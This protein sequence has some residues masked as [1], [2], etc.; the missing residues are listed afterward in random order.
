MVEGLRAGGLP[1]SWMLYDEKPE[2]HRR[3]SDVFIDSQG[4]LLSGPIPR[5]VLSNGGTHM[6]L[7]P[8][9]REIDVPRQA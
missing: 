3:I 9:Y 6:R 5:T 8:S 4:T 2:Q 7:C 1:Y